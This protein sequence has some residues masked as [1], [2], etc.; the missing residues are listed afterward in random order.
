MA[1]RKEGRPKTL[2]ALS[3]AMKTPSSEGKRGTN[4]VIRGTS[5]PRGGHSFHHIKMTP[6]FQINVEPFELSEPIDHISEGD[7]LGVKMSVSKR[8]MAI[9]RSTT[10]VEVIDL[11]SRTDLKLCCRYK[12]KNRLLRGGICWC[13]YTEDTEAL[14]LVTLRGIE[15]HRLAINSKAETTCK[16]MRTIKQKLVTRF[17][18]KSFVSRGRPS[19][20]SSSSS[21]SSSP[22]SS[23]GVPTEGRGSA[24][25]LST[26]G[27]IFLGIG[28]SGREVRPILLDSFSPRTS[29]PNFQLGPNVGGRRDVGDKKSSDDSSEGGEPLRNESVRLVSLYGLLYCVH[30]RQDRD[31]RVCDVYLVSKDK[32]SLVHTLPLY[33][34]A[35]CHLHVIDNLLVVH[36]PEGSCTMLFDLKAKK[37]R[38]AVPV[39]NPLPLC[40]DTK[41]AA[42][43]CRVPV[44]KQWRPLDANVPVFDVEFAEQGPLGM[45]LSWP[46]APVA[47]TEVSDTNKTSANVTP[48]TAGRP[49]VVYSFHRGNGDKILAA[50]KSGR[51]TLGDHLIAVNGESTLTK[52]TFEEVLGMIHASPRPM[53]LRFQQRSRFSHFMM[54]EEEAGEGETADG[55]V[56]GEMEDEES[57]TARTGTSSDRRYAEHWQYLWPHWILDRR[58]GVRKGSLWQLNLQ[59]PE[60]VRS[61]ID[62]SLA[63]PLVQRRRCCDATRVV[64]LKLL[65]TLVRENAPLPTMC[66]VF[67]Q[68]NQVLYAWTREESKRHK[69]KSNAV[70]EH[71]ASPS[72]KKKSGG[73]TASPCRTSSGRIVLQMKDVYEEVFA[74][75]FEE[76]VAEN[77]SVAAMDLVTL[78][79]EYMRSLLIYRCVPL[80][81]FFELVANM[82]SREGKYHV[83]YQ[84]M[85]F[86][87]QEDS[88][89]IAEMAWKMGSTHYP[90]LRQI[91]IDTWLRLGEYERIVAAHLESRNVVA[92]MH[93]VRR[94]RKTFAAPD[95]KLLRAFFFHTLETAIAARDSSSADESSSSSS[96][97]SESSVRSYMRRLRAFFCD[98]FQDDEGRLRAFVDDVKDTFAGRSGAA[99][100]ALGVFV[101][102]SAKY[103]LSD[104]PDDEEEE[105]EEGDD[106]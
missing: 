71:E 99:P 31:D 78:V 35:R 6:S 41:D 81:S 8:F 38:V 73:K 67:G 26:S 102:E 22:P 21:S 75:V 69:R 53:K 40:M 15:I 11:S 65:R 12:E 24:S 91:A 18:F 23:S 100:D 105:E 79:L 104:F 7:I 64:L 84:F 25:S 94:Y 60:V 29:M 106:I 76:D 58:R 30:I 19:S 48:P 87:V 97:S 51:I 9:Q 2:P 14:I 28:A 4:P 5:L 46:G 72:P 63:V 17:W 44:V 10:T 103:L 59:L 95:T 80:P 88:L 57:K 37:G 82:L 49:T 55:N 90:P 45:E 93:V 43:R 98:V 16:Y 13:K 74:R 68:L 39:V 34:K 3:S 32:V 83:L 101:C 52:S 36:N 85:Q 86:H 92:A 96:S 33:T 61:S 47:T 27:M 50:E 77:G 70:H 56:D 54:E 42:G 89:D 1:D 62:P 20:P 66:R